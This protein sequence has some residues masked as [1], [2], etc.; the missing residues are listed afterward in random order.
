MIK[1]NRS[2]VPIPQSLVTGQ[3]K[4]E[5][6]KA[7]LHYSGPGVVTKPFGFMAYKAPDV[8][9]SLAKLFHD[10]CAYCEGRYAAVQ[11][12]DVE[13]YRPK[14][15]V[16]GEKSH[17]GYWWLAA[18]W[19]N[20]LPSCIDCNRMRY[21][22]ILTVEPDVGQGGIRSGRALTGKKDYF[23][24]LKNRA[25]GAADDLSLEKPLLIDPSACDP[26]DHLT[27]AAVEKNGRKLSVVVPKVREQEI[28]P[29]AKESIAIF[30]LN[31]SKLVEE[32]TLLIERLECDFQNL[33]RTI[34]FASK[35]DAASLQDELPGIVDQLKQFQDSGNTRR[36]YSACAKQ[37]IDNKLAAVIIELERLE[38]TCAE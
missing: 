38:A 21:H 18:D 31:R 10:K 8:V 35:L 15:A 1:V 33:Q 19:N 26:S 7:V 5:R 17:P 9:A 12:M 27:W 28:D 34:R 29:C 24:I 6:E 22:E 20:L 3:G 32:R 2:D 11:P 13:H 16:Y 36:P 14:G 23:P 25:T 37:F 4:V 30:G